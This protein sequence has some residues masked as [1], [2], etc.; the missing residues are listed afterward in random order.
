M[1]LTAARGEGGGAGEAGGDEERAKERHCERGWPRRELPSA[2]NRG[3]GQRHIQAVSFET[4][5]PLSANRSGHILNLVYFGGR[6]TPLSVRHFWR[7][8]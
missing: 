6:D 1:R 3:C 4:E 8:S 7:L 2:P 5:H